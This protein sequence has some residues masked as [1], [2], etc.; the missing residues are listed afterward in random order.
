MTSPELPPRASRRAPR[1]IEPIVQAG[2]RYEQVI[3]KVLPQQDDSGRYLAA[4][5]AATGQLLWGVK[6]FDT[7]QIAELERDV[8]VVYF[9]SMALDE[10]GRSLLIASERGRRFAV[11]LATHAVRELPSEPMK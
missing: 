7:P 5:D 1:R 10:G 8:Q 2:V 11:D 9:A 6:V 3:G 4:F